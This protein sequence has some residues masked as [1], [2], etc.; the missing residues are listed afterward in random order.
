MTD[1]QKKLFEAA[2]EVQKKAHAPYSNAYIGAAVLMGDKIFTGCNVENASY[3]GTVCAERV[4]IFKAVSEGA[5][6]VISEVLVVSDAE[7]PWPPCGFCR[8]VIAEFANE[9]TVIHTANLEGKIK[10]FQFPEI[11][12]EAFTPKHLD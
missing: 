6:K 2:C 10:S 5:H 11:F 9:Q 1:T 12:P 8:Q 4:A 3:G 7:K